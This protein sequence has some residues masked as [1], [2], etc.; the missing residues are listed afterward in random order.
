MLEPDLI[1]RFTNHLREALQK[2][3]AFAIG[4]GREQVDPGDLLVG[5]LSERGSIAAE[6]LGKSQISLTA[7]QDRF[8]GFPVPH[9]PGTPV[10]PDLS[11]MVKRVLEKCVLTAHLHEHRYVGTEHL[12]FALLDQLLPDV[13]GFLE[14]QG[15]NLESAREHVSGVLKST[16]KFP[17]IAT[18]AAG[19]GAAPEESQAA[20]QEN[21]PRPAREKKVRAL[22][23]FARELTAPEVAEK[24]DP[25]V[26]REME[27]E[28][29]VEILCRR[30]KNNPVLLGEP[31]VGKTAIVEGLA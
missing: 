6:V 9:D 20:A 14:A 23:A 15:M 8:R 16:S 10:T 12:L 27:I 22:E 13:H 29:V 4:A 24:L 2:A 28:R 11:P 21:R 3:L 1:A 5:L 26:G 19:E 18:D 7:A 30:T 25:V 17:D 31:G